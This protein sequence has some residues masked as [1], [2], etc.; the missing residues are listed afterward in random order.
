MGHAPIT[1]IRQGQTGKK[2]TGMSVQMK[3]EEKREEGKPA[4]HQE[5]G[6]KEK[7]SAI[8]GHPDGFLREAKRKR[9]EWKQAPH[10]L[11]GRGLKLGT[12]ENEADQRDRFLRRPL[13]S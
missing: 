8:R 1:R 11:I 3:R 7:D 9:P 6:G 13:L 4:E 10:R 12:E 5:E 2:G